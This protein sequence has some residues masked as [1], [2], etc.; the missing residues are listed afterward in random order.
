[1]K[2]DEI[3]LEK[4]LE[5]LSGNNVRSVGRPKGKPRVEDVDAIE[6]F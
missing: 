4:A 3:T 2:P 1:M 6:A 5:L